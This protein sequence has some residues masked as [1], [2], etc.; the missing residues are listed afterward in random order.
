MG[1][2][3][4][5]MLWVDD[6]YRSL[7][8]QLGLTSLA[9]LRARFASG[10]VGPRRAVEVRLHEL[11]SPDGSR[12]EVFAKHYAYPSPSWAFLGRPSKARCEY[13]NYAIFKSLGIPCADRIACGEWRDG[14]GRLHGAL[15]L[16]RAIPQA[17]TLI[18][19]WETHCPT[20]VTASAR[21]LR[22]SLR[23]QLAAMTR[24]IHTAGFFHHDL[25][26]RNVLV[27][28][29]PPAEPQL[30]WIDCPRGRFNRWPPWRRRRRLKDLASLDK[31]AGRHATRGERLTFVL[32]YL[33]LSRLNP[34][35]KRLIRDT[36]AY[37]KSRWPDD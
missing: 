34:E 6:S 4:R 7:L 14:L 28:W 8:A 12:L 17:L 23:R 15:I 5:N 9:A 20:R 13:Q 2:L 18:D 35:A 31:R 27:T 25:V 1:Y 33:G 10:V 29:R 16:T 36:L 19:F 32:E 11:A 37:R 26:W 22:V 3:L 30:C 24:R 21:H